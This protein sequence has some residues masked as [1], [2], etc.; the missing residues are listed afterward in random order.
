M[1]ITLASE[2]NPLAVE[3]L[4]A[5]ACADDGCIG[6]RITDGKCVCAPA[7][8]ALKVDDD[9]ATIAANMSPASASD[10]VAK[11]ATFREDAPPCS[12]TEFPRQL[13]AIWAHGFHRLHP[14][15][16]SSSLEEAQAWCCSRGS[17][18]AGITFH[19]GA[20]PCRCYCPSCSDRC[21]GGA[22]DE[23]YCLL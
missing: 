19:G 9:S 2:D 3:P 10:M 23:G 4:F 17:Q 20:L 7:A 11:V 16:N 5:N 12:W 6:V 15:Y 21:C 8:T 18:C 13:L 22:D 1:Q 14:P